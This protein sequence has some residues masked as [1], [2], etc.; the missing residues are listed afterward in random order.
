MPF[1]DS[2]GSPDLHALMSLST[3]AYEDPEAF[4]ELLS[5]PSVQ[6]GIAQG[7]VASVALLHDVYIENPGLVETLLN[8]DKPAWS[9]SETLPS[10]CGAMNV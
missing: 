2:V 1:M 10:R 7:E 8:P 3:I 4:Q 9:R 5:H 6:D